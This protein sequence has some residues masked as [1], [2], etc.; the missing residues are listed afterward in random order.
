[1]LRFLNLHQWVV[2]FF[3]ALARYSIK[4]PKR[5]ILCALLVTLA[6]APGA[7]KLKLRTDGH[8]LVDKSAPEVRY[9][10]LVRER[11][12][13][14]DPVV[15]LIEATHPDGIYNAD[16]L[17]LVR[18]LTEEFTRL[19][20]VDS[21][22]VVSLANQRGFRNR[23][24]TLHFMTLLEN[25]R[26]TQ[27][28]LAELRDD[29]RRIELYTG[30]IV[31]FDGQ[32]TAIMVG[33]PDGTDRTA[34]YQQVRAVISR[35]TGGADKITVTGP[36]VAEALLGTHIL[37]DLGV[38][39]AL[40]GTSTRSDGDG[41]TGFS[42]L[43]E[44]RRFIARRVGL[45]P[46]AI[47]IMA[48]IFQISFR[49]TVASVLPLIEV[50]ACL[51]FT[52]GLMG[53]CG[54]PVYLTIAVMPVLLTAMA[55]TDEIHIYSRYFALVHERPS[56]PQP[57]LVRLTMEEMV[58]PIANASLT[59]AIGFV[60]FA[61]SP[62][63]PVQAFGIFTA[64]GL[65]F[66]LFWTLCVL[67]ALLT[68]IPKSWV[69]TRGARERGL[70]AASTSAD[71]TASKRPV[72]RAPFGLFALWAVRR[73]WWIVGAVGLAVALTPLGL[74]RLV[75][76]DSWIDGFEPESE[77]SHA[78]RTINEHYHGMHLLKVSLDAGETLRGMVAAT[79]VSFARILL[80]TNLV[81]QPQSLAGRWLY[82]F[83]GDASNAPSWRASIES[84]T[85]T[86]DKLVV[87]TQQRES[88]SIVWT[89][90]PQLAHVRFEII[91]QPFLQQPTLDAIAKLGAFIEQHRDC[92]VGKVLSAPDYVATTRF[93]VRPNEAGSRFVPTNSIE[94]KLLWDY[95]RIVR[96]PE[97]L[98]EAVDTNH[99]SAVLTIFLKEANFR[100]TAR[101]LADIRDY[102]RRELMPLN[103]R[104][105]FAGDVAVSQSLI[106]GIVTTQMQSLFGSLLGI[107]LVTAL[108][109]RS[110][111]WGLYAV[112][113]C[114]LAVLFN[115][116]AMGWLGIP[117][118]VATSMFAAMTLGNGVD[119]AIHVLEGFTAARGRGLSPDEALAESLTRTGPAVVVNT[120]AI[121]LGFGVLMLSQVPANARLGSLIILGIVNC[122]L[123]SLFLLPALLHWWPLKGSVDSTTSAPTNAQG[124]P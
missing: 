29:L 41:S 106:R 87:I 39:A 70:P 115:F 85:V 100:D 101:L 15:V 50:G 114:T 37:E 24:A 38:P 92:K 105:G 110:L 103:I 46:V 75:I 94:I 44:L 48:L 111:R 16:T 55:V 51:A 107:Y 93:M 6:V 2:G 47:L 36:P 62:L 32:S 96:G 9:D 12:G 86:G 80:P 79:N 119:F 42:N 108:L 113:P 52:F 124:V 76:Q 61:F 89:N 104:L 14:Q 71:S 45:V 30:T 109:G 25:P 21:N 118:G 1:M 84:A 66:C 49:R 121:A 23:P 91:S 58:C 35:I 5:V 57:D 10:Q 3:A 99:A 27:A 65:I 53:Y 90:L 54:V 74:R 11:F 40:L 68:L 4:H 102:E 78:T 122:L 56:A 33:A 73:R 112:I 82:L 17:Q 95:Y 28:Q 20:G 34:L 19:K 64:V 69:M 59:T 8:A 83:A 72:G 18:E 116:T 43:H 67:P 13:I 31:S 117:L 97:Q 7:L 60:S 123:A 81:A 88:D 22:K 120:L 77:F 63:P 26:Q 98:R